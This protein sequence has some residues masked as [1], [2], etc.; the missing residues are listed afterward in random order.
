MR[1]KVERWVFETSGEVRY[2]SCRKSKGVPVF[3]KNTGGRF[4]SK[5]ALSSEVCM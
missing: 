4:F 3:K 2:K 5:L 1:A